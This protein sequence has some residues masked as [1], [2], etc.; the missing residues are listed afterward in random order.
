MMSKE[1][2]NSYAV[3]VN[4]C[5]VVEFFLDFS[6][7]LAGANKLKLVEVLPALIIGSRP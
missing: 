7:L 4:V 1:P 3:I 6:V 5:L 2:Y